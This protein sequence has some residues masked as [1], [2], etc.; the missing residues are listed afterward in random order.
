MKKTIITLT[1]LIGF[2]ASIKCAVGD[3]EWVAIANEIARK[4]DSDNQAELDM[5]IQ[6]LRNINKQG[7]AKEAAEE[8]SK[9]WNGKTI[10]AW[11]VT[12]EKW[13]NITLDKVNPELLIDDKKLKRYPSMSSDDIKSETRG[14]IKKYQDNLLTNSGITCTV[15]KKSS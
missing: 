1:L 12:N 4:G 11:N 7:R 15:P 14:I 10:L 8:I 2:T 3:N 5:A 9:T 6:A 13:E